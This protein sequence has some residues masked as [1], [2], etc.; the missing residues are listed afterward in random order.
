MHPVKL[1]GKF[2]NT[3][4]LVTPLMTFITFD[5]VYKRAEKKMKMKG[6]ERMKEEE[7]EEPE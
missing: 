4:L 2:S 7:E 6:G 5:P 3:W 1:H